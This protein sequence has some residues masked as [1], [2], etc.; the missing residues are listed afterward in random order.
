MAYKLT[1]YI[2]NAGVKI[3][4]AAVM[5]EVTLGSPNWRQ[6]ALLH[7]PAAGNVLVLVLFYC[8][9]SHAAMLCGQQPRWSRE[10]P[11]AM[12]L[13]CHFLVPFFYNLRIGNQKQLSGK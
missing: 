12:T 9:Y 7:H 3:V 13:L 1:R 8:L 2:I 5:L 6:E 11:T 4:S 10:W